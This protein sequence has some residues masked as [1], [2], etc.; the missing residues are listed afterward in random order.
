M[1]RKLNL[2][3]I[4]LFPI[5]MSLAMGANAEVPST[6][7]AEIGGTGGVHFDVSCKKSEDFLI[8]FD[9]SAGKAL[10][11]IIPVCHAQK[12]GKWTQDKE[13]R[14][15]PA[16][17]GPAAINT[18]NPIFPTFT[19]LAVPRCTTDH[20]VTALHVW[21]DHFGDV[22]HIEVFCHNLSRKSETTFLT[23]NQGGQPDQDHKAPCPTDFFAMGLIGGASSSTLVNRLGLRCHRI[24]S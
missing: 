23:G 19:G 3:A 15:L 18:N 4:A 21:W 13:Y 22:H 24:G 6:T 16:I 20:F 12:N 8:G 7:T 11:F 2:A 17:G 9:Y 10:N 1:S 5:A 14:L